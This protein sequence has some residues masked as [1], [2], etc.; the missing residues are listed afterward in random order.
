MPTNELI[1]EGKVR[2]LN[3][4]GNKEVFYNP[5]AELTRT[6]GVLFVYVE[7]K[8]KDDAIVISDPLAATGIRGIRYAVESQ[9]VKRVLFNDKSRLAYKIIRKNVQINNIEEISQVGNVDANVFLY[10]HF[11]ECDFIDVDPF[12]SPSP[13]IDS[14]VSAVRNQGVV[15][16]TSTDLAPLCG[17]YTKAALR[18]YGSLPV[19]T[20]YCHEVAVRILIKELLRAAGRHFKYGDL[21]SSHVLGQYGRVYMRISRGKLKYRDEYIGYIIHN[22]T[23]GE[24]ITVS[25]RNLTLLKEYLSKNDKIVVSGPLWIGPLH[26]CNYI[27]KMKNILLKNN[28]F[29]EKKTQQLVKYL[30]MFIE[31]NDF[32]P[33]YYNFHVACKKLKKSP[34]SINEV[35]DALRARGFQATRTHFSRFGIK[36]TA[37]YNSFLDTLRGI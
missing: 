37:D 29:S 6:L 36:T 19:H 12:G 11:D 18:K 26:D 21:L 35:I 20:E 22:Y 2:I 7:G 28:L 31:E 9:C 34:P 17:L 30:N 32:P 24:I 5:K 1:I 25:M 14:A 3:R 23:S 16:I 13:F 10:S 27:K 8:I 4:L 33:F 15:A